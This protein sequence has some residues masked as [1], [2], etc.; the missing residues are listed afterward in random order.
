MKIISWNVNGI[1]AADKKGFSKWLKKSQADIICLQ[2]IKA[3]PEQLEP[4][5][6]KVNG[7]YSFF[8]PAQRKGYSGT[9]VYTKIKPEKIDYDSGFKRFDREGRIMKIRFPGFLLINLY[10]PHG[11]RKKENMPY[12]L[13]MYDYF[14]KYF[15]KIKNQKVVLVGDFNIAHEEIDLARP[16]DNKNNTMFTFQERRKIDKIIDL[17]FVDSFRKFNKEGE[18]YTWWPYFYNAR[19]RNLGWRI[20]YLFVSKSLVLKVKKSF[21]LPQV[22]GSDH[23]PIGIIMKMS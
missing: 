22:K 17:G 20:D 2:E 9:A 13:E 6:I 16:K 4:E 3:Q 23:C 21:I 5:L 15:K 10:L 8:N 18:N 11:G 12:K 19:H 1:R 7:Y 14:L